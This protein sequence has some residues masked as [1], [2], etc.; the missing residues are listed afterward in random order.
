MDEPECPPVT[1][2]GDW[3]PAQ[4][5]SMKNKLQLYFQSKKKSSGGDCRVEAE[6]G[7]PRAAVYFRSEDVRE[8]VLARKNHE[9]ILE[10]RTVTLRLI[11]AASPTS[12]DDTSGATDSKTQVSDVE[13]ADGASAENKEE[14]A[15]AQ[16]VSVV[17]D[18]V[19]DNMSRDLLCML[20]ENV[21]GLDESGYSLEI[22]WETNRAVVTFNKP[23]DVERFL[24]RSS[25]KL[26]RHGLTARPL[27]AAESVQVESLPPT[28]VKEMLELY[29][30]KNWTLPE[31]IVMI[32]SEQAAIATFSD[33]KVV[34]SICIKQD[35]VMRTIPVKMYPYHESL[36]SALYGKERPT[37]KMPEPFTES[38]HHVVWKFLLMKKLLKSINDQMSPFFCS[39]DLDNPEVKLSPLPSF[40]RQKG[41]TAKHVD[42]WM[43]TAQK[44]FR[45][46]MSQY[47]AF[48]CP[49][50]A[51]AWKVA[52][53]DV[54]S[55][56][57]ENAIPVLDASRGVLTLAGGADD[58]K[59]IKLPVE[60]IVLKAMDQIKRQT[61]SVSEIMNMSPA[62]FYILQQEGFQK[63]A[64]DISPDMK[65]SFD[66]GTQKLTITGLPA[67]VF[68]T[69]AWI[70]EKKSPTSSDDTSGE[71]ASAQSVS[72]VLDNVS[73]NMSRDLLCM[74]VENV[75]G[76][77]ES[78]YSLEIIWETNRAVVTFNKPAD[79][80][81]FLGRS[82][83]KLQRHGLTARP[84]EAAESVRVES[85]PP[86]VVEEMLELYFEKN[87]TLP[88]N[89]VMI[90]SEQAAIATFSDPKVVESICIKQDYVMR[91]IP[92]KMYPYHE[93]LGS[94]LYGKE[95]PTWK[96]PEPFTESVHHVVWK[97]LLM[98][99]LLKS[100]NDQMS[101]FF[102][103][104][105][106]DNPE[107][108]LSP[109]PSFLRQKGLTA[110]HVDNW[111]ST[112]Q[113]AF[114][115][116]MSQYTAFE[117][118][119]NAHAWKVAE[120]D[121]RSV[122]RENAIPV[123]DASRGVLT[124]AGGADDIKQ[125][126]APVE[127]I[128]LKAMDQIKRQT[129]SVS[130]IMNMSPAM[131]YIL[132]QEGF[133]KA[134]QDIS[135]DM[136]L[137]FDEGTQKLTIT[138]LPAEVFQTKAWILEKKSPTSSD[139]TSG[140]SASA[141]SISVVLDNV[142]SNMSR[143]LLCMLVENVSGLDESGYSLEIIWETNRAVVTFNKPADVERFLGRSSQ[144]LQRH[145]L[146][147]RLLEAA[148]SVRVESLPPTV[149]KEMLELY[150]EK[151]WTLP[152]NIVMIPSEQAAIA[153]FSDPKVVESICI[154]QDYVMRTIPV[155]MYPYHE[156]LGS[157]LYGKERPTW[158][159]P[160]PFTESV[161]HVVWKFLLMKK[162]LKSINDQMSPFFCSVDLDNPEVKLSP[163]PSF[164]RQKGLTAKHVDNWMSTAQKAFREQMSQ[165]TAFEC[166]ANAH[167]WK[168]AEKDVC[169]VI[170]ENAIPVLDASRGIL[171]LAGG[172][173]DIKQIK[174]PV[175][176]IV[177]KAMDQIKRQTDSV[178]EIMNMSPAMFY[179]LQQEGFQKAAQDISPDMKLSFDEGTQKLTITGLPAEGFQ[180]KAW[181][182]EKKVGMSKKQLNVP[183]HLLDFLKTVDPMV[184]S[185]CLFTSQGISA[186]YSI[187]SKGLFLLGSSESVLAAAESK[188][189]TV[190]AVQTLDV[191]D[192]EVLKLHNWVNLKQ[193]LLD[194]YNSANK[195][196]VAI[197]IH[198]ERRDKVMVAGF[199]DPVKEVT[200]SLKELIENYSRV[201]ET[202]RVESCAVVQFIVKKKTEDW[203]SI[204]K[205]ND[206][207]IRF[208]SERPKII[209]AGARLHVQK[210]KI[211]FQELTGALFT[212]T[213]IV[214]K[215]GAKKYFQTQG[216]LFLSTIMT[217]LS[218]VV[219][220][221]P[222]IQEEEEGE[223]YEEEN[224]LSYCKVKTT[225]GVLVSVSKADICS[226][227]VDAVVNA[228]NEELKHIGGLAFALLKA[229]GPELQKISDNHVARNG[230]LRAGDAIVTGA[231]NLP[232]K[233]VVHAVGPRFS[234][235]DR[236]TSV[237]LLN[238][239]VKRS[240]TRAEEVN[241]STIALPAISSGVFCFPVELC[242]ETIAQ[243]VREFC[244]SPGGP[245]SL[246]EIHLVDNNDKTV[247]VLATA[248][249]KA[250]MDLGPSMTLPQPT[251][252]R[253]TGASG[254]HQWGRGQSQLP[255]VRRFSERGGGGRGRGLQGNSG[256]H[257]LRGHAWSGGH[258]GSGRLEQTTAE[259]LKIVLL[260]GNIQD[261]TCFSRAFRGQTL[262]RNIQHEAQGFNESPVRH[263]P[264]HSASP[265]QQSSA[266]F[267][268]VSS[269][270]LGVYQM[271]MGQLTLE[272]SSGD[273][274]KE[275]CDVIINSSNQDFTL[276][277][278]VSKAIL[279]SAGLTVQLECSQI[280]SSP[281]YQP[282]QFIMT[283]G[284]L[285]PSR[286]IIHV[287][288]RN[289][290]A[291]IK[292]VVYSLL[293]YCEENKFKS[294]SFPALGTAH[295]L[296][297]F[298]L[299]ACSVHHQLSQ[300]MCQSFCP[301]SSSITAYQLSI[302]HFTQWCTYNFLELNVVK[303]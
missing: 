5:K 213:F 186:I 91:T 86:T 277:S 207:E 150:F 38:V 12:S 283:S 228:A 128:V 15:S 245:R 59:Q 143:D 288:C 159:M 155:K 254:G 225:S 240:L 134:A 80:E 149:V 184:M 230:K 1:V 303:T 193:Q 136:K 273:I 271:K 232:C 178:S 262:Q 34:E 163:L 233:H 102:C 298:R 32:P 127:N 168:V 158:K 139:D 137:S 171:T 85:L 147:A 188:M 299:L 256:G 199:Q 146:T 22:I 95:R 214:D 185:Q 166:P 227:K 195:R 264:R 53:K 37:W 180:T 51:H 133:Q 63:A 290:P 173:D 217:E 221:R 157:A 167:A 259:G 242:A 260:K 13:P 279:D 79:V 99:K 3:S 204:A 296:R 17:L 300:T 52:E 36:G 206:V 11:S 40:L 161:H 165:Y 35:Y 71:S 61:D 20:V 209:L 246:T 177:L 205:A 8:R 153:T 125:I 7:A 289:D 87:W 119:A 49:A 250:F 141:Q 275:A 190:L 219:L 237:S 145:G 28:V 239:A 57:R 101:P 98:K 208:D 191:E 194:A 123:L 302:S 266:S 62:M 93:S 154:K 160:E 112:A 110:K 113:K 72:V 67:E 257:S 222:E 196:T 10:N 220:L 252:G 255:R 162:L 280:V 164:L 175:E 108:K 82:S 293:K 121:V 291:K 229:A 31:N 243:A 39:V 284:G 218:C 42:N 248:V 247:R 47:T 29:F 78:G 24:G 235:F 197:Q 120:K 170:R 152:E 138:G 179:I 18:N 33:P 169:S 66:E 114:R 268:Q 92:V 103:S 130:E 142:S 269:P 297:N 2:E 104:V 181:I 274:T 251:E 50:N 198:P 241:C 14:S 226:F 187:E 236:K 109:L 88:E 126:K 89:I 263:S 60:N 45:E 148:E 294:V 75:S 74:L 215:P 129:D 183:P 9:I 282:S 192:Q 43:S 111:M 234:D 46:Q 25:Q 27:E 55:V 84:L 21:S 73:D 287:V 210:A 48:E 44:A 122:I 278:G 77:D 258:G 144:K 6:D 118:P 286:H 76:L 272:V 107:V 116:Q 105:D 276:K 94:A 140:E 200:R 249:N 26:Q 211:C 68:Q 106:L 54:R 41:L 182:L 261:Q 295:T 223:D 56:I 176:N 224:G 124:L 100:I 58:I 265:P 238:L 64:Q 174:A 270:S 132:Q 69:K 292:E 172:A 4:T 83:Q 90:P 151:N 285:L 253:D 115:E 203:I 231:Y 189:K 135:P 96:M 81:R 216:S 267:S 19:S 201:Q 244:D 70:L 65:L 131:F 30:E 117:C 212:D 281:S 156:S 97:F 16:R 202:I 301:S 23:A